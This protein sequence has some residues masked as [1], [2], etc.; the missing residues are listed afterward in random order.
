MIIVI[1]GPPGSGKSTVGKRLSE[2]FSLKYISAGQIFRYLAQKEGLSLLDLNQK[3]EKV[4]EIDKKIDQEI[5]RIATTEKNIIIESHIGGWLLKNIADFSVYLNASIETRAKR[6]AMRD[7]ISY[8]EALDQI[9][10]REESHF[11]RFLFYYGIDITDLSVFDL[12]INSDF[13]SPDDVAKIIEI[14][15]LSL[16]VKKIR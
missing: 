10:K 2:K 11:K 5:F 16:K 14:T 3:A 7:N 1:S 6:I 9:I 4:F 12:V 8:Y 13:I 15:L